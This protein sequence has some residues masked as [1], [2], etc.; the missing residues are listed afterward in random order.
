MKKVLFVIILFTSL[1]GTAQTKLVFEYDAAGNQ[2][3]RTLCINCP[4][5]VGRSS[6][7]FKE[8]KDLK[9]EDLQKFFPEDVISYYPNP[10]KEEL[11]LKWELKDDK[12]VS[13]V[14]LYSLSGQLVGAYSKLEENNNFIMSFQQYPQGIYGLV[15][16]YNNGEKKSLKIIKQ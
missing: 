12:R 3:K 5:T 11:F 9:E 8:I 10:V 1:I 15:L 14:E 4:T 16:L 2:I 6:Q 7:D 13:E